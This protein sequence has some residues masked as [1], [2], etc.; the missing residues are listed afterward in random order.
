M[1]VVGLAI[2]CKVVYIA[3][4]KRSYWMEVASMLTRDSVDVKPVRG[5]ILSCDGR[6]MASSLPEYRLF[7]DFKAGG[8]DNETRDS[9][10]EA[11]VDSICMGLHEIFPEKTM[12]RNAVEG[13]G[14]SVALNSVVDMSFYSI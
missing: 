4:V 12:P 5:N 11:K 3:T 1:V 14:T 2:I 10:W 7:M 8:D 9:L 13:F 6:L